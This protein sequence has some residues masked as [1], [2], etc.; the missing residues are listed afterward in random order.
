MSVSTHS[1]SPIP[2][3]RDKLP[4]L[5]AST[6]PH[7][8]ERDQRN[9][10][11]CGTSLGVSNARSGAIGSASVRR[12]APLPVQSPD[13]SQPDAVAGATSYTQL[14]KYSSWAPPHG[15]VA[16]CAWLACARFRMSGRWRRRGTEQEDRKHLGLGWLRSRR[17]A[18]SDSLVSTTCVLLRVR[19]PGP[20]R[21]FCRVRPCVRRGCGIV[22]LG[23]GWVGGPP[24]SSSTERSQPSGVSREGKCIPAGDEPAASRGGSV[25]SPLAVRISPERAGRRREEASHAHQDHPD[26]A[27][28]PGSRARR[29][30]A[31]R[32]M[33]LERR[34]RRSTR[35]SKL[36]GRKEGGPVGTLRTERRTCR[37]LHRAFPGCGD[38][39]SSPARPPARPP[40]G[41]MTRSQDQAPSKEDPLS[42][43]G[44]IGR[45]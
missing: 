45:N 5:C 43:A 3:P 17:R 21:R 18:F 9:S 44:N 22:L 7:W 11:A 26:G 42:T 30:P 40:A 37:R 41:P 36:R 23:G 4:G 2:P 25:F 10:G 33:A 12:P 15:H 8:S 19:D 24:P 14:I 29:P 34:T 38:E 35:I 1:P 28:C 6:R 27:P 13:E 20:P 39:P 16:A 31:S 32:T